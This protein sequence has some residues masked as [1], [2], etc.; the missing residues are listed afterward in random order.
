M[1]SHFHAEEHSPF[2]S[3][4]PGTNICVD[5]CQNFILSLFSSSH[6][7]VVSEL[8]PG[9]TSYI[10]YILR[11][12]SQQPKNHPHP[13]NTLT[14]NILETLHAIMDKLICAHE[15]CK[16]KAMKHGNGYCH[17]HGE[18]RKCKYPQCSNYVQSYGLCVQHGYK[19]KKMQ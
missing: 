15:L 8:W 11:C 13:P 5:F 4:G 12:I 1:V 14:T 10:H 18:K 3:V 19:K 6:R 17:L 16:R 7:R 2:L 9:T